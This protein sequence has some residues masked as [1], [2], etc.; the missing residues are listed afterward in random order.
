[1]RDHSHATEATSLFARLMAIVA[2]Q[3]GEIHFGQRENIVALL[4]APLHAAF[5]VDVQELETGH[6]FPFPRKIAEEHLLQMLAI[7][8]H[9][10]ED[11]VAA[12][13]IEKLLA[14]DRNPATA[15]V[16]D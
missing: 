2:S 14:A 7:K 5:R 3:L 6:A 13:N 9:P 8:V 1:M 4:R 10:V 11:A 12:K 16:H 15:A